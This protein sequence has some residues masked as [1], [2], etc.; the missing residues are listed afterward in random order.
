MPEVTGT[1]TQ[2]EER[3]PRERRRTTNSPNAKDPLAIPDTAATLSPA[4]RP[5][6]AADSAAVTLAPGAELPAPDATAS[7]AVVVSGYEILGDW[8]A[9]AWPWSTRPATCASTASW[10]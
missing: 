1:K 9:A 7:P 2:A 5:V 10:P 8:A 6:R 4:A 3:M